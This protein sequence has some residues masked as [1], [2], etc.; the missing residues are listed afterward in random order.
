MLYPRLV[1]VILGVASLVGGC[2]DGTL[3]PVT[4]LTDPSN[5][6]AMEAPLPPRPAMFGAS[7]AP[8]SVAPTAPPKDVVYVCPMHSQIVGEA[9]GTCPICSMTRALEGDRRQA[10]IVRQSGVIGGDRGDRSLGAPRGTFIAR[11][12]TVGSPV[13]IVRQRAPETQEVS[14]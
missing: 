6:A 10:G 14:P 11:S 7:S 4:S 5:P 2:I 9:P 12:L 3:P 13:H 1:A 8:P